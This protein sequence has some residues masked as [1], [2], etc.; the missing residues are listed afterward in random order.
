MISIQ[1]DVSLKNLSNY[2]IGGRAKYFMEVSNLSE[3]KEGLAKWKKISDTLP[4][5][6]RQGGVFILGAGTNVLISDRGFDALV[7]H[8]NIKFIKEANGSVSVGAGVLMEDLLVFCIK[9]SLSGFE[10]AGGLP[11]TVGGA[12]R[13]NA[14]AFKGEIKDNIIEVTSLGIK[15]Q[16]IKKR[17]LKD[18]KFEYRSSVF[19]KGDREV[20]ISAKLNLTKGDKRDIENQIKE[21]IEYRREKHP[22]EFPNIGSIFKNIP[23][24]KVPQKLLKQLKDSIKNDPFP[25]LPTAK[26]LAVA[27]LKGKRVGG[28]MVSQKHPNFIVNFDNAS[29]ADVKTLIYKIKEIIK[30]KYAITLEEEI[31]IV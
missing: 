25:I 6:P 23:V 30:D 15:T 7:I 16:Q 2:K 4:T 18:C 1:K 28:A 24:G 8:P 9:N 13:G 17:S 12:V 21:K 27:G 19:K 10:W 5:L 29:C 26:L 3:L 20:I 22:L 14:G 11:G 31:T